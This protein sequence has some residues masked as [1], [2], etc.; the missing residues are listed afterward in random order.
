MY[1][2]YLIK[3]DDRYKIGYTRRSVETRIKEFKTGNSNDFKIISVFESKWATKIEANLH[4]RFKSS[5]LGGEWFN[6]SPD[7]DFNFTKICQDLHD[8]FE[9]LSQNNTW[10]IDKSIL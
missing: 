4:N 9:L 6:L 2:V 3:T 5:N 1:K 7:I 10:I 8:T